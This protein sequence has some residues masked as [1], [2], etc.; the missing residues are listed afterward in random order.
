MLLE[1]RPGFFYL[2]QDELKFDCQASQQSQLT[3]YRET[4]FVTRRARNHHRELLPIDRA[5]TKLVLK[6]FTT[7]IASFHRK[8]PRSMAGVNFGGES[9]FC[10]KK[11]RTAPA[12]P[13]DDVTQT[14]SLRPDI[15]K[16]RI[17]S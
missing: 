2:S 5:K 10:L 7:R 6:F 11:E 1:G 14:V 17:A 13:T 3:D 12:N 4:E 8:A 15:S 16:N 9:S